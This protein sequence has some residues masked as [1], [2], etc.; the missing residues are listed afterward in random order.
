MLQ[1]G[2]VGETNAIRSIEAPRSY[3]PSEQ[4]GAQ[5]TADGRHMRIHVTWHVLNS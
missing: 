5:G 4:Q 1:F 3:H 2:L